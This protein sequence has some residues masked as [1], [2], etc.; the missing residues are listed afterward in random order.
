M[1]IQIYLV[2]LIHIPV[3]TPSEEPPKAQ[4]ARSEQNHAA[5]GPC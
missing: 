2:S 3:I 4:Q 1:S 5:P